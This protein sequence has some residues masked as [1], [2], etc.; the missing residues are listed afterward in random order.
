M[1]A[2]FTSETDAEVIAHLVSHHLA[3]GSLADAV[4]AAYAELRG[5]LRVRRDGARR[6]RHAGR[7]PQGVPADHRPRRGRDVPGLRDPRLPGAH[8]QGPVHRERRAG[9]RH[10]RRDDVPDARGRRPGARRR[11]DRLGRGDRR[12]GRLRDLHAQGDPRAGRR[13][14]RDDRRPHRARRRRGPR[15]GG[16]LR[17]GAAARRQA[18][19]R[20]GLR[21][22]VPRR[23]DRSLRD[24]GV[25]ADP[26]R[27]GRGVASTATATRSSGP[28][29]WSSASRSRARRPTRWRR[30]GWRASVARR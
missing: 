23:P 25:G 29:I 26:G 28:A 18:H 30:C 19:H 22:L 1:G 4:R 17:R 24:R 6:A 14:R 5:P 16:E 13:R 8:A 21:D 9:R 11:R 27:D 12:E 3:T 7:R 10:A 2:Q 15:R 20:R